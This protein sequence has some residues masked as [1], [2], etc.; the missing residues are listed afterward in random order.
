LLAF[1]ALNVQRDSL[2]EVAPVPWVLVGHQQ[3]LADLQQ[4]APD[5]CDMVSAH[6][7]VAGEIPTA[8]NKS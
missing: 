2:M 5:F 3:G 7:T 8:P 6:L 1:R 4:V